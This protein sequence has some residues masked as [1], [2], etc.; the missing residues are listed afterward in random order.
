M[1][2]KSV[3]FQRDKEL[4]NRYIVEFE[5]NGVTWFKFPHANMTALI[6]KSLLNSVIKDTID[7]VN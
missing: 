5:H 4:G 2:V 3:E 6:L 7:R 1:R